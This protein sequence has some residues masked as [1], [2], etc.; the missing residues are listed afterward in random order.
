LKASERLAALHDHAERLRACRDCPEVAGR[1]VVAVPSRPAPLL[2]LGQ[3][4]GPREESRGRLFA[5]TAG[6]RLFAW[7]GRLGLSEERFRERA[8]MA[9][10]LRC[11]PGR[12]A[13]GD[14]VPS[15]EEIARCTR[16][17]DRELELIRPRT[18]LAVGKLAIAQFLPAAPLAELVGGSFPVARAGRRFVVIPLPHPSGRSTWLARRRSTAPTS[19]FT[20]RAATNGR[21]SA[22]PPAHARAAV[23]EAT[24]SAKSATRGQVPRSSAGA[25][26]QAV[27]P[28]GSTWART[29]PPASSRS[30]RRPVREPRSRTAA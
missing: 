17:L 19:A 21:A 16:H 3:A 9:A 28:A 13:G 30:S 29:S 27:R 14:R 18:V 12:E 20:P 25:V 15:D 23:V 4:P 8:W 10:T 26:A 7:L 22:T 11:F 2:L 1:P 24:P 5:H 6:Q